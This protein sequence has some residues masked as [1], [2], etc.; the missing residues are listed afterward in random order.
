MHFLFKGPFFQGLTTQ[1]SLPSSIMIHCTS[2]EYLREFSNTRFFGHK[3]LVYAYWDL[4]PSRAVEWCTIQQNHRSEWAPQEKCQVFSS[5]GSF[6]EMFS[7]RIKRLRHSLWSPGRVVNF[8]LV[9]AIFLWWTF[10]IERH[11]R[12]VL[13]KQQS[14]FVP[15]NCSIYLYLHKMFSW[16]VPTRTSLLQKYII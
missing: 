3:E 15:N 8:F 14:I 6:G 11:R 10:L 9:S 13:A 5:D 2:T 4:N 1:K 7:V 16:S 12:G